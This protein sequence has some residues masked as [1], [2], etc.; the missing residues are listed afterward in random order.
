MG[1][2]GFEP[3]TPTLYSYF[4][5]H[6]APSLEMTKENS[7]LNTEIEKIIIPKEIKKDLMFSLN[8]YG[9]NYLTIYPDLEGL[10]K[11]LSWFYENYEYWHNSLEG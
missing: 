8:Q 1:C 7:E 5:I 4:T 9:F 6:N 10:S 11:H 3:V 2:T